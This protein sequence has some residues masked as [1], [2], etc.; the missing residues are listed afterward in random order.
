LLNIHVQARA[1][2]LKDLQRDLR[3]ERFGPQTVNRL[4]SSLTYC[5]AW[6]ALAFEEQLVAQR[7]AIKLSE[8][9]G[10]ATATQ[11]QITAQ[12]DEVLESFSAG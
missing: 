7:A 6:L 1:A 4:R 2:D 9:A 12:I 3:A 11:G 8:L 5:A 10:D